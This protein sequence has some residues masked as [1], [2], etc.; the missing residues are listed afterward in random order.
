MDYLDIQNKLSK[1]QSNY[2]NTIVPNP[3]VV[4]EPTIKPKYFQILGPPRVEGKLLNK[5]YKELERIYPPVIE[6]L[7]TLRK[8]NQGIVDK[9]IFN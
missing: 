4:G 9:E 5:I 7:K 6:K 2:Q 8:I 3:S 1:L